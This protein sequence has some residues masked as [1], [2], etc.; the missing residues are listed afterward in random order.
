M[1]KKEEE[2]KANE[3]KKVEKKLGFLFEASWLSI[4]PSSDS[5][6]R[7]ITGTPGIGVTEK[8]VDP[9]NRG[10]G[11]KLNLR[12]PFWKQVFVFL[13][14]IRQLSLESLDQ[15]ISHRCCFC[16]DN[17]IKKYN[18]LA[19]VLE[20]VKALPCGLQVVECE[21]VSLH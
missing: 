10:G 17:E 6:S 2:E 16:P 11:S 18:S 19:T 1:K 14:L 21:F 15:T 5:T 13:T 12:W 4:Q 20:E 9:K 7:K 3:T 8:L